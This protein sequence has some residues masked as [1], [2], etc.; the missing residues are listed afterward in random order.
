VT[1]L[2][3]WRVA[4]IGVGR[5]FQRPTVF[6]GHTVEE[7][8]ELAMA[9]NKGVFRTL[10]RRRSAGERERIEKALETIG[11][12]DAKNKRAG[13][14][15]HGHKHWLEIGMLL[16]QEPKV[17]LVDEPVAGMSQQEMEKTAELLTGLAGD[18][19]VI[20]VEHDMDFVRS[21]ARKVTVLH[22]GRVLVEGAM[23]TIQKDPRV[24]EVYLGA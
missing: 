7:N 15:S 19:T 3:E 24:I 18:R 13:I 10:F 11:L 5:K 20:V 1:A 9:G 14:L 16:V 8:L 4:Q 21:I 17:L 22:E 12:K 23:D 6:Q 2:P